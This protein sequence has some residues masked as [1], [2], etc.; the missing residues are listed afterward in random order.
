MEFNATQKNFM[1]STIDKS[2]AEQERTI[3]VFKVGLMMLECAIGGFE[4]FEQSPLLWEALRAVFTEEGQQTVKRDK[5]CCLIHN[6]GYL[7]EWISQ[8]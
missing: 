8:S 3:D 6:E 2:T 7:L 1:R 4:N 5:A